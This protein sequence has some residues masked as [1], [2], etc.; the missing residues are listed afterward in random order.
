MRMAAIAFGLNPSL[1]V[2][3]TFNGET[4]WEGE[5]QGS[6]TYPVVPL[7]LAAMRGPTR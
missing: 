3:K 4:V 2:K 5:V 6:L 1:L 7:P